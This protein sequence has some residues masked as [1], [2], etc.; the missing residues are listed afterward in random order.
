MVIDGKF[1]YHG[2]SQK[3]LIFRERVTQNQCVGGNCLKGGGAW[4]RREGG[5]FEGGL[6]L[7]CTLWLCWKTFL[8]ETSLLNALKSRI[9]SVNDLKSAVS[10][11]E[12]NAPLSYMNTITTNKDFPYSTPYFRIYLQPEYISWVANMKNVFDVLFTILCL[13]LSVIFLVLII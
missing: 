11:G 3:N 7:Q 13:T 5:I 2:G 12:K 8:K 1:C 6:I 10:R 4:Q 9:S